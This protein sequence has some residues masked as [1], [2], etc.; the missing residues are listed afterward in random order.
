M[1]TFPQNIGQTRIAGA[2]PLTKLG[3]THKTWAGM[4]THF[5]QTLHRHIMVQAV[6]HVG[7]LRTMCMHPTFNTWPCLPMDSLT[8]DIDETNLTSGGSTQLRPGC[9]TAVLMAM[10]CRTGA[11]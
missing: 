7:R 9:Q 6:V 8:K 2:G 5:H 11:R 3:T 1:A 10:Q 4:G